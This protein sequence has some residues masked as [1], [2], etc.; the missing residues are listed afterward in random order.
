M[1]NPQDTTPSA[2]TT[3]R[4]QLTPDEVDFWLRFLCRAT[5][6]ISAKSGYIENGEVVLDVVY[7]A[8]YALD[9]IK[10]ELTI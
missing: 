5:D 6:G 1:E 2:T 8:K 4:R 9:Y 3:S 7:E 10:L